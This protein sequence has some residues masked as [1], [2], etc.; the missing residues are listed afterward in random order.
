MAYEKVAYEVADGVATVT[1]NDPEKRNMLSGQM[2]GELV[3]AMTR[4]R[5]TTRRCA[6]WS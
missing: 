3:D 6:R 2:L 5:A 4:R 1:L